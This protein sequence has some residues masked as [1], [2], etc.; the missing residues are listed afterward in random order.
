MAQ[1]QNRDREDRVY[2]AT[3]L[4]TI[5]R[6]PA[7]GA[8]R[9]TIV[10]VHGMWHAAWCWAE[11][12]LPYFGQRGYLS[13]AVSLRGHG[14]SDGRERLRWTSL[15]DY[16]ADLAQVV[17]RLDRPPVLVGHS[18]GGMTIL[19]YL[20]SHQ[21][22]AA[23]LLAPAPPQG[24]LHC[25]LRTLRRYP[26]AFLKAGLTLS[27]YPIV[28]SPRRCRE[29][30]F[31]ERIPDQKLQAYADRMQDDSLRALLDMIV[32]DLPRPKQ[33]GTPLLVLGA[34]NDQAISAR[35]V[36]AT[37]RAYRTEAEFFPGMGHDMMLERDWELVAGRIL[38]WLQEQ[39]L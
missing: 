1:C 38:S 5:I 36:R 14:A 7:P 22:L 28:D 21:A 39:D 26:C 18:M 4:E 37:A 30:F 29:L 32:L 11:Y 17:S 25:T 8:D 19:K 16:V 27:L 12:F 33:L 31:S 35:E 3:R 15:A 6:E 23:V 9:P 20:E 2:R 10:F 13:L 34:A 24:L